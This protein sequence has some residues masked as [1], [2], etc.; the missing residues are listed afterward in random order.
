[1]QAND[2]A[3]GAADLRRGG[4]VSSATVSATATSTSAL[5]GDNNNNNNNNNN[6]IFGESTF[7]DI[8]GGIDSRV[9][10]GSSS[11]AIGRGGSHSSV[12]EFDPEE[13]GRAITQIKKERALAGQNASQQLIV[14][15]ILILNSHLH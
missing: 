7:N 5:F 13:V 15:F 14:I 2:A 12:P 4:F 1:M 10:R 6:N 8:S 3:V 11:G 9:V